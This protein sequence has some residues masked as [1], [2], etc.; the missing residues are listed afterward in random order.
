MKRIIYNTKL[1][2]KLI[3]MLLFMILFNFIFSCTSIIVYADT[4]E[5]ANEAGVTREMF[6]PKKDDKIVSPEEFDEYFGEGTENSTN[7]KYDKWN[8]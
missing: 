5:S 6:Y 8:I 3:V 4:E 7:W 2:K 1:K